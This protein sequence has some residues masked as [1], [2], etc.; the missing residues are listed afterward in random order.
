M[1]ED[2]T[3]FYSKGIMARRLGNATSS[4]FI[5]DSSSKTRSLLL[6]QSSR[7]EVLCVC[8]FFFLPTSGYTSTHLFPFK[9]IRSL[10]LQSE[11]PPWVQ[12]SGG[13]KEGGNHIHGPLT[14]CQ[15]L[16]QG[17]TGIVTIFNDTIIHIIDRVLL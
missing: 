4:W 2:I 8:V 3:I 14:V 1:R 10:L 13:E 7:Y 12:E 17:F 11:G 9:I 6:Q 15:Q 16:A 5:P